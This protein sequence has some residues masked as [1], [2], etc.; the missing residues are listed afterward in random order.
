[1]WSIISVRYTI[2]CWKLMDSILVLHNWLLEI[3]RLNA[4]W[5]GVSMPVSDWEGNLG[6][7]EMD[8]I[9]VTIPWSLARLSQWLDPRTLDLSGM[10][11]G[12]NVC[13]QRLEPDELNDANPARVNGVKSVNN[14]SLKAFWRIQVNHFKN[15]FARNEIMWPVR[16]PIK[17]RP[18]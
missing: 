15:L 17:Q 11:P 12:I 2:G 16:R 9:N 1:M 5:S 4:D 18:I 10:G 6:D 14:M 3:D 7:C 8:G 13:E